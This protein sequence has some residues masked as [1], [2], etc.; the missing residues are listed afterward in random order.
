[1]ALA[2]QARDAGCS[3]QLTSFE[4]WLQETGTS[5]KRTTYPSGVIPS[6][7]LASLHRFWISALPQL[8]LIPAHCISTH[9]LRQLS[10]ITP[11]AVWHSSTV[12]SS[13]QEPCIAVSG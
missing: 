6:T 4:G 7:S 11:A 10:E 8:T 12:G 13:R 2:R 3:H 9:T 5:E 1:M